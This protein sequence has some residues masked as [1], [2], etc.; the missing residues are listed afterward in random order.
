MGGKGCGET[1]QKILHPPSGI[2]WPPIRSTPLQGRDHQEHGFP[3]SELGASGRRKPDHLKTVGGPITARLGKP[4]KPGSRSSLRPLAIGPSAGPG[5][6]FLT[7]GSHKSRGTLIALGQTSGSA[8]F[9]HNP[10][11]DQL[12]VTDTFGLRQFLD[13]F[14]V[15]GG[16]RR[17]SRP[18][19][20]QKRVQ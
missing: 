8:D 5:P 1:T 4:P 13:H 14:N 17:F 19:V 18:I 15:L 9:F 3:R 2:L 12:G 10:L 6:T 16:A 20:A 7:I 11:A